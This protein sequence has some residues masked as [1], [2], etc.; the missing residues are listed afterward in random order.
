M[1]GTPIKNI[2][3]DL[4]VS[5]TDYLLGTDKATEVT[6]SYPIQKI[7]D[8]VSAYTSGTVTT[9]NIYTITES[10]VDTWIADLNALNPVWVINPS[11]VALLYRNDSGSNFVGLYLY[12][13]ATI[14]VERIGLGEAPIS[15]A[16]FIP[17][18]L[19]NDVGET[20]T[21][22]SHGTGVA[23]LKQKTGEDFVMQSLQ[24]GVLGTIVVSVEADGIHIDTAAPL[25]EINTMSSVGSGVSIVKG[26]TASD[27]AVKSIVGSYCDIEGGTDTVTVRPWGKIVRTS[28]FTISSTDSQRTIHVDNGASAVVITVPDTLPTSF[29][30]AVQQIGTGQVS[31]ITSG[32]AVLEYVEDIMKGQGATCF[33]ETHGSDTDRILITGGTKV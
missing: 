4:V 9:D 16:D 8:L 23:L 18:R 33:V 26:K 31:F 28:S 7:V 29:E 30:M 32:T 3:E 24:G 11:D 5:L 19:A 21:M 27:L 15:D 2:P 6:Y 14:E 25:G 20:N 13:K 10:G 1:S 22:S 17:I 12:V